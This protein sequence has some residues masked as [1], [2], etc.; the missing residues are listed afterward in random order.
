LPAFVGENRRIWTV[1]WI[2]HNVA[3]SLDLECATADDERCADERAALGWADEL[4]YVGGRG[5]TAA[6][7]A[8]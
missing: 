5:P 1:S 6:G 2:E 8:P 3:Y 7:G 4:R